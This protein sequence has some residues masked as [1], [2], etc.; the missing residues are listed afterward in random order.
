MKRTHPRVYTQ[1]QR[2]EARE[3]TRLW[4]LEHPTYNRAYNSER[5]E[6]TLVYNAA[7]R[8]RKW[9]G[10][11][12]WTLEQRAARFALWGN[13]CWMCGIA[14]ECT[15]HVKPLSKGGSNWPANIRPACISCNARKGRKWPVPPSLILRSLAS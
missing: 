11:G 2:E 3:R 6:N 7:D 1:E 14:A 5:P 10:A 9:E 4:R 8:A 13:K 12:R 15:D